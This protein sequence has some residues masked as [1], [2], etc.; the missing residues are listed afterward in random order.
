MASGPL[1]PGGLQR[2]SEVYSAESLNALSFRA[3][4]AQGRDA[5][6]EA[7][8]QRRRRRF[9]MNLSMLRAWMNI[10]RGLCFEARCTLCRATAWGL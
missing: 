9:R 5:G 8:A 1:P 6:K 4:L 2:W 7:R 10:K 3:I